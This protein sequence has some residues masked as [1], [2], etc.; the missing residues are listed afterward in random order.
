MFDDRILTLA[1]LGKFELPSQTLRLCDGGQVIWAAET[2]RASDPDFGAID[3]VEAFSEESGDQAPGGSLIFLPKDSAAAGTLSQPEYQGSR[4]RFW[5][6]KVDT[7]TGEVDGTPEQIA[8]LVL[9]RTELRGGIGRLQ[10]AMDFIGSAERLFNISEGNVLSPRF[11]QSV[12]SGEL[13]LDNATGVPNQ[14]AWGA[15]SP[16][17]GSVTSGGAGGA[18]GGRGAGL[19]LQQSL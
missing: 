17:R 13:G 4:I 9:D 19:G 2:F 16:P 14:M 18:A 6:A 15:P 11:H 5:L 3:T 8:D 12:W 10:L 7:A 1:A